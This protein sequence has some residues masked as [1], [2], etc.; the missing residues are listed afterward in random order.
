MLLVPLESP[1]WVRISW[2][3]FHNFKTWQWVRYETLS[4]F[5]HY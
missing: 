5:C 2:R 1:W 3:W 4:N